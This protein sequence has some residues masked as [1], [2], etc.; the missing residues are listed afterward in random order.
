M[1]Q[2]KNNLGLSLLELMLSLGLVGL[3]STVT[4]FMTS[5]QNRVMTQMDANADIMLFT[6]TYSRHFS[7]QG[8]CLATLN[9]LNPTGSGVNI[10]NVKVSGG[11]TIFT[12][13]TSH[14]PSSYFGKV[15]ISK[16][17]LKAPGSV[18]ARVPQTVDII[19]DFFYKVDGRDRTY[20]NAFPVSIVLNESFNV[21][22]CQGDAT[23]YAAGICTQAGGSV[24]AAVT[25]CTGSTVTVARGTIASFNLTTCPTGWIVADGAS[26]ITPNL[27]NRYIR[28]A[29]IDP[30]LTS[31]YIN[32]KRDG[33]NRSIGHVQS[34][35][36]GRHTHTFNAYTCP[37]STNDED[38]S[39]TGGYCRPSSNRTDSF[40][41][42]SANSA[43]TNENRPNSIILKF[44]MKT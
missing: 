39:E 15:S 2:L 19:V 41:S 18:V 4:L 24:N 14:N 44:C 43:S 40:S 9:N 31:N 12:P 20:S 13:S 21:I 38:D 7:N 30:A 22:N 37:V 23:Q 8:H 42:V 25:T 27:Q 26:S 32:N 28:G 1:K 34:S 29:N 10:A 6:K 36:V 16:M 3:L 35:S 17:T 5:L 33:Q 11:A